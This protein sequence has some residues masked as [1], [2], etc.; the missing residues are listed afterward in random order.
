M[1]PIEVMLKHPSARLSRDATDT[2]QALFAGSHGGSGSRRPASRFGAYL[3]VVKRDEFRIGDRVE[4]IG[5]PDHPGPRWPREGEQGT[6]V[7][8]DPLDDVISWDVADTIACDIEDESIRLVP[9]AP[10]GLGPGHVW[11]DRL[12]VNVRGPLPERADPGRSADRHAPN[13]EPL[14]EEVM[15]FERALGLLSQ[16][17]MY[18][19]DRPFGLVLATAEPLSPEAGAVA[20]NAIVDVLVDAGV[21]V[22]ERKKTWERFDTDAMMEGGYSVCLEFEPLRP[23]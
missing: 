11:H 4:K 10:R 6:I 20:A 1:G 12:M 16:F 7:N 21:I 3:D 2:R 18:P 5:P 13:A 19:S 9:G 23:E 8:L 17:G 22:D 15:R 14:F